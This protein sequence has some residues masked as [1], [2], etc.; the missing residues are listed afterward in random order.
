ML[1]LLCLLCLLRSVS[2]A[3]GLAG[4]NI[5]QALELAGRQC[6][7]SAEQSRFARVRH[8]LENADKQRANSR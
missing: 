3:L 1:H 2:A 8:A 7:V 6:P 4:S 5:C